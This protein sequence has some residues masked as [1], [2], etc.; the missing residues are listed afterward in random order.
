MLTDFGPGTLAPGF[1]DLQVNGGGGVLFNEQPTVEGVKAISTAHRRFGTTGLLPTVITDW[2]EV[3]AR[4]VE[5]VR[6][7]RAEGVPGVVGIHVEGPFLDLA[8]RGAHPPE[9]VRAFDEADLEWLD[10]RG[11][12]TLLLTVSPKAVPPDVIRKLVARGIIVSLGHS[13]ATCEEAM[14]ALAAGARCF[15]HLY[16]AMSQLSSRAPGMVGAALS[17]SQSHIGLIA[18]GHHV[19]PAAIKIALAAKPRGKIFLVSDAMPTAAGGPDHFHLQGRR[20][21][22]HGGRLTLADG[23][24]AG[25]DLTMDEAVRFMAGSGLVSLE[26]ALRMASLYPAELLGIESEAGRLVAGAA[27]DFVHLDDQLKAVQ[28]FVGGVAA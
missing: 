26:E 5:A 12:G 10:P 8:R 27:A 2:T 13:D 17:D 22:R 6:Q 24:L 16:N 23:T 21:E 3:M 15:T 11:V 4:A 28:T 25:S 18:D 20:V 14:A 1:I 9:H 19:D 7:A